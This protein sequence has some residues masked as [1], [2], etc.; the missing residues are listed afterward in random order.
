MSHFTVQNLGGYIYV[1]ELPV[2]DFSKAKLYSVAA[3]SGQNADLAPA[4][5]T[6]SDVN[7]D[8]KLDMVID[9]EHTKYT[10]FNGDDGVFHQ[11]TGG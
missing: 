1:Y 3:L 10:F 9:V 4:I 6:F 11:Q 8:G 2:N 5:V 7:N